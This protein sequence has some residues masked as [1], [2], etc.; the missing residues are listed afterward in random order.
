VAQRGKIAGLYEASVRAP[1]PK[2]PAFA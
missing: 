2:V 1:S